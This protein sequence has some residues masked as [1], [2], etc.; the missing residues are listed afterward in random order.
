MTDEAMFWRMEAERHA[1]PFACISNSSDDEYAGT[2]LETPQQRD[3]RRAAELL[4][5]PE[6]ENWLGI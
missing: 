4:A 1:D 3:R 2:I 6:D 5:A